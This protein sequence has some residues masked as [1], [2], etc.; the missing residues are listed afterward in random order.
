MANPT[1]R[2]LLKAVSDAARALKKAARWPTSQRPF[3]VTDDFVYEIYV[4]VKL[5]VLLQGQFQVTYV[6][7]SGRVAHAFPRKPANKRG[8]PRFM[9]T[10]AKGDWQLCAGTKV[11]DLHGDTRAPDISLQRGTASEDPNLD[12]V[13]A[14]WDAKYKSSGSRISSH[15]FSE[16]ARWLEVLNL[17]A[18]AS[19]SCIAS[20]APDLAGHALVTNGA[21]STELEAELRRTNVREIASYYPRKAATARP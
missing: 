14:I 3:S 1:D 7:G 16:F 21:H 4:Y 10:S 5:L 20:A 2:R 19:P 15:E 18:R 6:P 8:R 17:R 9:L 13:D 12:D 11:R